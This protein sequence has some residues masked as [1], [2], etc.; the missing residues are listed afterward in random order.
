[1][2]VYG[3]LKEK[4]LYMLMNIS[5]YFLKILSKLTSKWSR[6][7]NNY[8]HLQKYLVIAIKII[9]KKVVD[10]KN[11][12]INNRMCNYTVCVYFYLN[13]EVICQ[14]IKYCMYTIGIIITYVFFFAYFMYIPGTN[15]NF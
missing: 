2:A 3:N 8:V 10:E 12:A 14:N 5:K 4:R 9:K 1:M 6:W 11:T 13:D 15:C 7:K